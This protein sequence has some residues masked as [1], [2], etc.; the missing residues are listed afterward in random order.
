MARKAGSASA[1]FAPMRGKNDLQKP[2]PK[3]NV[4]VPPGLRGSKIKK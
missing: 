3:Q 2:S 1:P 4:P